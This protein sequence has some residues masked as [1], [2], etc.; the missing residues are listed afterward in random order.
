MAW[1]VKEET[2][3]KQ[4]GVEAGKLPNSCETWPLPLRGAACS[5][6]PLLP[7]SPAPNQILASQSK[8]KVGL[9]APE[10]RKTVYQMLTVASHL[11]FP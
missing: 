6:A 7:G 3:S 11:F 8:T 9:K 10:L 5:P 1:C 4:L 2:G